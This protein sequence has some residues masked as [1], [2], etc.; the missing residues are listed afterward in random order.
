[1][2]V[3]HACRKTSYGVLAVFQLFEVHGLHLIIESGVLRFLE[4]IV[5]KRYHERL[6]VEIYFLEL[7]RG[8]PELSRIGL[9]I[10]FS[11]EHGE[12]QGLLVGRHF[13]HGRIGESKA[14]I[15]LVPRMVI[16]HHSIHHPRIIISC[17][18]PQYIAIYAIVE[19]P[20]RNLD[21]LLCPSDVIP[22]REYLV[23]CYGN[24][25]VRYEERRNA[26][27]GGCVH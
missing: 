7:Q 2:I 17:V 18:H 19:C 5:L 14:R 27:D 4:R 15:A 3:P 16:D 1:M 11:A 12:C 6:S 21:F 22:E 23:V 20:G 25:I 13:H 8:I 9:L 26:Y 24:K 10:V